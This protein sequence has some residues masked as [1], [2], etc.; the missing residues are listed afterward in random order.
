MLLLNVLLALA[1]IA[2][3][4]QFTPG[5][6]GIGFVLG[7]L[8]IW[9]VQRPTGSA[10][11]FA[12]V[13][14]VFGFAVFF[15][16][17]LVKANLR[18]TYAVLTLRRYMRPGVIAV[19]LDLRSEVEITLFANCITLTPGTLSLDI[20]T[21]RRVLYVHAMYVDDVEQFRRELK[22]GL[23]RRVQEVLQ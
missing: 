8:L 7:Y 16:W 10:Q 13:R 1:W 6:L 20:S 14:R 4:G 9:L 12:K 17:E 18:V 3:T 22:A 5:N 11:Y 2:L 21:D 23:E 19:P 15:L